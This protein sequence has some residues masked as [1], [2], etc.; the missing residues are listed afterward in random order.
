MFSVEDGAMQVPQVTLSVA[1]RC[2]NG[3]GV[4]R[5]KRDMQSLCYFAGLIAVVMQ[6]FAYVSSYREDHKQ[7]LVV[8]SVSA[9]SFRADPMQ[10]YLLC[11]DWICG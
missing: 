3:N 10:G 1:C 7:R 5:R 11:F 2:C 9:L 6:S 8:I 4:E